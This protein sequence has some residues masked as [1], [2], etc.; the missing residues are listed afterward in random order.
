M[1]AN[2]QTLVIVSGPTGP[3]VPEVQ[4][5]LFVSSTLPVTRQSEVLEP[6]TLTLN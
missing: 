2:E 3:A 6:L 5:E 4:P 1:I